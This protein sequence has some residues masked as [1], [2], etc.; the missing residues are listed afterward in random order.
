MTKTDYLAA[1]EKYLKTLPEADYKEAMDYFTEYFE[2]AGSENEAQVIEEL[3]DPKDAAE[4]IIRSLS[5]HST[6][7]T[8]SDSP[9]K[10]SAS[11][12]ADDA[13]IF[14]DYATI[15][16]LHIDVTTRDVLIEPSPDDFFHIKYY[17]GRNS[18]QLNSAVRDKKWYITEKGSTHY[19]GLDWIINVMKNGFDNHPI[20]IQIPSGA[21]LQSFSLQATS[22][23]VNISHLQTQKGTF[24]LSSGDLT[25]RHCHLQHTNITLISGDIH[26]AHVKLTDCK[27]SLVSGDF[28]THSLEIA[29]KT[30]IQTTSGDISLHL[31]H[32]DFSYDLETVHGDISISHQ[33]QPS[34]QIVG[35]TIHHQATTSTDSLA[36]QAVSGDINLY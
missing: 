9:A 4:E 13:Y 14:E 33:L 11:Q 12:Y 15:S 34:H 26:L 7:E 3:G 1:L 23:D 27:L 5:V 32:H 18:H 21:L 30:S 28:D 35:N 20:C 17:N 29:G 8:R 2:E 19:S 36:I 16:E 24:E 6:E 25:M 22:G 10:Q 31:L